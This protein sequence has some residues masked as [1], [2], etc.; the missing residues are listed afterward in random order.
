M[1][2]FSKLLDIYSGRASLAATYWVGF[3]L[4]RLIFVLIGR[5]V[6]KAYIA[7][8]DPS[9]IAR[10]DMVDNVYTVL[11]V[12]FSVVIARAIW[13]SAH[14]ERK[15]GFW[16]W[17]AIVLSVF[18][19]LRV[20]YSTATVFVPGVPVPLF[21]VEQELR[22]YN[23]E[24]PQ[25]MAD[26]GHL[27]SVRL[28]NDAIVYRQLY[29]VEL[30]LSDGE[31]FSETLDVNEPWN[32]EVCEGM[33]NYFRGGVREIVFEYKYTNVTYTEHLSGSKCLNALK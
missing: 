19:L 33:A 20:S 32:F 22:E 9:V 21:L 30:P 1:I 16:G 7:S 25:V 4:G 28:K 6:T 29:T 13:K 17:T 23:K 31:D 14:N 15:P 8:E 26:G 5:A 12:A 3:F 10:L 27:V 24:L 18:G 11:L 2:N